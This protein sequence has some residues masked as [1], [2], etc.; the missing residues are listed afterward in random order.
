TA[1]SGVHHK[2][3]VGGVKLE[4]ADA[5][6]VGE[7]Y[8]DVAGRLGSRVV[9]SAMAPP[10]VEVALGVVNDPTFGSLVLVAAGGVLVELLHDRIL[11]FPPL[12]EA[13]ARPLIDRLRMR[14]LLD[15]ARGAPAADMGSLA[16]AVSRLAVL[17]SD[18]G[19]RLSALDANPVIVSPDGCVAVDA[20]VLARTD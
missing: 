15:G 18:L 2:S 5:D 9:V 1:A 8:A 17:A 6:A 19:D 12:D 20:L 16:H 11:A 10:G 7:A 14:P 3:D 4:L 13:R